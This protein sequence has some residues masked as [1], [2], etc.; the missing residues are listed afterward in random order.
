MSKKIA[1]NYEW[2]SA[3]I[4]IEENE[5]TINYMKEQLLFWSGGHARIVK[6]KGD[7]KKA[8]LKMLG[9]DLL[10]ESMSLSFYGILCKY[11][12]KEGW[13]DLRGTY[14]VTLISVDEW[15]F[16]DDDFFIEDL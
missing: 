9:E 6:E 2:W 11:D 4:E 1:I 14:G 10:V 12:D 7:I 15:E 13:Y 3:V 5:Q 8:Y 16:S